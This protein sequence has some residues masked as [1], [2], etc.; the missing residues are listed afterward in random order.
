MC[1]PPASLHDISIHTHSDHDDTDPELRRNSWN[2][3]VPFEILR[4]LFAICNPSQNSKQT[5]PPEPLIC[6]HIKIA[7][8]QMFKKWQQ[9]VVY[10]LTYRYAVRP[11]TTVLRVLVLLCCHTS[12]RESSAVRSIANHLDVGLAAQTKCTIVRE[13]L[14]A[15]PRINQPCSL[16]LWLCGSRILS[17]S[18]IN[19]KAFGIQSCIYLL[20]KPLPLQ[21][22]KVAC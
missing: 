8:I 16:G 11:G 7:E 19:R 15:C 13:V 1:R 17:T 20:R 9:N 4:Q 3:L 14:I 5:G 22:S 21:T 6:A 18:S 2:G 12:Q 10:S